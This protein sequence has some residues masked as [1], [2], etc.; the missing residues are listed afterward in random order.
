M[1]QETSVSDTRG[2]SWRMLA[3]RWQ[4]PIK[5][6]SRKEDNQVP[7]FT[8]NWNKKN[9]SAGSPTQPWD[10]HQG[11]LQSLSKTHDEAGHLLGYSYQDKDSNT[12]RG[13]NLHRRGHMVALPWQTTV[14]SNSKSC[15]SILQIRMLRLWT[16]RE[17]VQDHAAD[18]NSRSCCNNTASLNLKLITPFML[19]RTLR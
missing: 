10:R 8:E 16:N 2:E 13:G 17:L 3:A 11:K 6:E 5:M 12:S 15:W 14:A 9:L 19:A 4:D 1:L 18:L 7:M